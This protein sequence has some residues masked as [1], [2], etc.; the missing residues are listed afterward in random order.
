MIELDVKRDGRT[1]D[2]QTLEA[3]RLMAIERV[4]EGE[5]PADVIAS[6]GF[7]RTT[8]YKW[9]AAAFEPGVGVRA[10]YS[11][12]A[13]G[14]PRTLSAAQERQVFRWIN[15]RDPR[16]YGL[17][18]GFWTRAI[19]AQLIEQKF[20]LRLGVTAVGALL[21]SSPTARVPPGLSARSRGDRALAA[22]D[23]HPAI[24]RQAKAARRSSGTSPISGRYGTWQ[25]LGVRARLRYVQRPASAPIHQ[26]RLGGQ[27]PWR[28]LVLPLRRR[29]ST[30][31]GS[32]NCSR[33]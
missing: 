7:N 24:V 12:P 29:R 19:V 17:D 21:A 33:R 13:S 22:R 31:K 8:I 10:L 18:F 2:H 28:V 11:K 27:C 20:G 32:S 16:Q 26:R 6:Y 3:I 9:M 5:R 25:H 4:R 23:P 1:F 30:P 14:R 15:G